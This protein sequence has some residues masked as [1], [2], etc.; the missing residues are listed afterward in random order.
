MVPV[1]CLV[2]ASL[3]GD[4]RFHTRDSFGLGG[5]D[6][7]DARMGMGAVQHFSVEH[8]RQFD[9]GDELGLAGD[10]LDSCHVGHALPDH[11][12]WLHHGTQ[13]PVIAPD[14]RISAA[15]STASTIFT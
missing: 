13:P 15:A 4:H 8:P 5:V 11:R 1:Y 9:V 6:A 7:H 3:I 14:R 10:L 12:E 2:G